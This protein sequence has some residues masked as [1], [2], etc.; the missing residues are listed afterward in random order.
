LV[1]APAGNFTGDAGRIRST[2]ARAVAHDRQLVR[3]TP[4]HT[5]WHSNAVCQTLIVTDGVGLVATR[6]AR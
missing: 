3:F 2:A 4:A 5:N 6:D 1:K